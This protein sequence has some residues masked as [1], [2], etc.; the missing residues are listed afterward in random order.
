MCAQQS[1]NC[2][3]I[4]I[5]VI[6]AVATISTAIAAFCAAKQTKKAA[7]GQLVNSLLS[8]FATDDMGATL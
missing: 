8:E 5:S 1:T 6:A 4:F 2:I 7:Q 3:P